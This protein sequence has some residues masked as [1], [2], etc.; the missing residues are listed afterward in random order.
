MV[1][2][3][4]DKFLEAYNANLA[5]GIGNLTSRIMKMA[6]SYGVNVNF[7]ERDGSSE[8][9][10][11]LNNPKV[12][13]FFNDVSLGVFDYFARFEF[14]KGMDRIW[15]YISNVDQFIASEQPY[16]KN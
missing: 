8:L 7:S 10:E 1:I 14:Q 11:A 2:F 5:N 9:T 15:Q 4:Q 3:T 12:D 13:K 16:K 6:T